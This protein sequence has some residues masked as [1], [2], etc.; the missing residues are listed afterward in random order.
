MNCCIQKPKQCIGKHKGAVTAQLISILVFATKIVQCIFLFYPKFQAS[1]LLLSRL[2]CVRPGE[3]PD[4]WFSHEKA[5]HM[6]MQAL[7]TDVLLLFSFFPI[8]KQSGQCNT[9]MVIISI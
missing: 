6:S 1:S 8:Y 7:L 5:H 3:N 4:C 9:N 2:V